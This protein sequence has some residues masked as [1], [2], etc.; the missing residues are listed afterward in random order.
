[1]TAPT[2][3]DW[4]AHAAGSIRHHGSCGWLLGKTRCDCHVAEDV[5]TVR[6]LFEAH[7]LAHAAAIRAARA[8]GRRAGLEEAEALRAVVEA[9]RRVRLC[10]ASD[11]DKA[12]ADALGDALNT[13]DYGPPHPADAIRAL[14]KE[15][16]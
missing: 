3:F 11:S 16:P 14:A 7:A 4:Y 12:F 5:E 2:P 1:M 13:L 8:E 6:D 10:K 15:T 9:A